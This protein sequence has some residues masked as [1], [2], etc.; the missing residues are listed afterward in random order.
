MFLLAGMFAASLIREVLYGQ[1]YLSGRHW[2]IQLRA[3]FVYEIFKKSLRRTGG[4]AL[5]D[6]E[7]TDQKASQ[8][9]IVS[10][11]SSDVNSLR[12]FL[13]D[14]HSILIDV[15]LSIFISVSGLLYMMVWKSMA[16]FLLTTSI[17][18]IGP[19]CFCWSFCNH[20][21][22]SSFWICFEK[23][24]QAFEGNKNLL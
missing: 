4:A 18:Y 24:L 7:A 20:Y 17:F 1:I 16:T 19:L 9:K 6:E 8:G 22:W 15:P 2:G 14:I 12:W 11:M 3:A 5:V 21:F 23:A 10:L 13:T